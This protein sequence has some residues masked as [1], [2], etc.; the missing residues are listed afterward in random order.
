MTNHKLIILRGLSFL[1]MENISIA[2]LEMVVTC[3]WHVEIFTWFWK[4]F[5]KT[6]LCLTTTQFYLE[7]NL[8]TVSIQVSSHKHWWCD[9][10]NSPHLFCCPSFHQIKWSH[11]FP[12]SAEMIQN[13][14]WHTHE[15]YFRCCFIDTVN[16]CVVIL[17]P[18]NLSITQS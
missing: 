12:A 9:I 5:N 3:H 6:S 14:T 2:W 11:C 10:H 18:W 4:I 13:H 16:G 8:P 17:A 1:A 7:L 15:C